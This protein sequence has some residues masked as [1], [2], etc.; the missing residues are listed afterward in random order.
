MFSNI[1]R[2]LDG[3][4]AIVTASTDGIGL[5]TAHKLACDGAS[6]MISSRR[7]HNVER[8]LSILKKEYGDEKIQGVVCHVSNKDDRNNLIQETIKLF[9]GIDIFV[10]NAATNPTSGSILDCDEEIWD[11]IFDVNVKSAFFLTKEIVPHMI[12]RGGGSIVYVSSIA[13]ISPM[14]MLGVYSV[15]KTALLGLTKV[16][17]ADLAEK[18][19][20][21]NCVAPGIVKTKFASILTENESLSKYI[22]QTVPMKRFG[23]TDEIGSVI[24]FLCSNASSFITGEVIVASGGMTSRL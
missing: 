20:R 19:I 5:A 21:V 10:S 13:G 4:T 22:L 11:K 1:T 18:N 3:K 6:V 12:S 9:G 16:I 2:P 14:P 8:A 23:K 7:K 15:S 17:A 24:S